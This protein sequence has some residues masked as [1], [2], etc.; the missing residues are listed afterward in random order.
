MS[1]RVL[2]PVLLLG[3]ATL[4]YAQPPVDSD[5]LNI[6]A[7]GKVVASGYEGLPYYIYEGDYN[8][9]SFLTRNGEMQ[10][11]AYVGVLRNRRMTIE[12][13]L[14]YGGN[15]FEDG[16]WFD[17]EAG[18]VEFQIMANPGDDWTTAATVDSYPTL[19]GTD[20]AAASAH[21]SDVGGAFEAVFD[22]PI[23]CVGI[24]VAGTGASGNNP[25]QS[26]VSI[27]QLIAFGSLGEAA[28]TFEYPPLHGA[29]PIASNFRHP[30]DRAAAGGD[31]II[32]G[33]VET[34]ARH[35]EQ[36]V[37]GLEAFFGFYSANPITFNSVSFI[38]GPLT[39]S[40][41]WFNTE[42]TEPRVEIRREAGAEWEEVGTID[43]YPDTNLDTFRSDLPEDIETT[44]WTFEF[45]E[46]TEAIGVRI[47]GNGSFNIDEIP[48][49]QCGE[50]LFDGEGSVAYNGPIGTGVDEEGNPFQADENGEFFIEAEWGRSVNDAYQIVGHGNTKSGLVARV[51]FGPTFNLFSQ[52][53]IEFDIEVTDPG[54]YSV[55][56]QVNSEPTWGDSFY[57]TF[58]DQDPM[59]PEA[60]TNDIRWVPPAGDPAGVVEIME[61]GLIAT[62]A[63]FDFWTL[64]AGVH[65]FR[66]GLR[67][68]RGVLDWILITKDF[69]QDIAQFTEPD[70]EPRTAV[71]DYSL[72]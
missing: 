20:M 65:T 62:D 60:I 6:L 11:P 16:G 21:T 4:A 33:I 58:D 19:N 39:E 9:A 25:G 56:A 2:I 51:N 40:G 42:F 32:D 17:S 69:Q 59:T 35:E 70:T 67:E 47:I 27:D 13:V 28:D 24:R 1:K 23:D 54:D 29:L 37:F 30:L 41:G 71:R 61:R 72:Y 44:V 14:F 12:R 34:V 55:F 64:D 66:F 48:F 53:F 5:T 26:F 52:Q 43:G 18:P 22:P 57:V 50:I 38:H 7:G 49:V 3:A 15:V 68:P 45:P 8:D 46:P 36:E 31:V 10:D 63:G